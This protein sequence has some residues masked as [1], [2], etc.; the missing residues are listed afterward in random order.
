MLTGH[1]VPI[2]SQCHVDGR[3]LSSDSGATLDVRNP[4]DRSVIGQVPIL[5]RAQIVAQVRQ[6]VD[7]VADRIAA[8]AR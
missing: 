6:A 8:G 7:Q 2:R 5:D 3:W 1:P 4:A